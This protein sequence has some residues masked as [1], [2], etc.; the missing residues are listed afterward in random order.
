MELISS[1]MR[2]INQRLMQINAPRCRNGGSLVKLI[3]AVGINDRVMQLNLGSEGS[4]LEPRAEEAVIKEKGRGGK[5]FQAG[6]LACAK[7][8]RQEPAWQIEGQSEVC[9]ARLNKAKGIG[10]GL[11]VSRLDQ[12]FVGTVSTECLQ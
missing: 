8:L 9:A 11:R 6:T 1:E 3:R 5:R 4:N 10:D 2:N 12:P 7:A